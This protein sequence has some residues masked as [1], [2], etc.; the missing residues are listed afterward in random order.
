MSKGINRIQVLGNVGKDP[1]VKVLN[2]GNKV[3]SFSIAV[4]E[5]YKDKTEKPGTGIKTSTSI[6]KLIFMGN[7]VE[8]TSRVAALEGHLRVVHPS[9]VRV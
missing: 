4:T 3:A 2:T 5:K 8:L 7:V 1:L 9:P 6:S